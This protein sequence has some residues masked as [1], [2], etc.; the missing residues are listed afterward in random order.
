[1]PE[2]EFFLNDFKY[3]L[4]LFTLLLNFE[5]NLKPN[6]IQQAKNKFNTLKFDTLNL[7]KF[8]LLFPDY[9]VFIVAVGI[10]YTSL[11]LINE[12]KNPTHSATE[13]M[14]RFK[15]NNVYLK[16]YIHSFKDTA[17]L[18]RNINREKD[19][20]E[21]EEIIKIFEQVKNKPTRHKTMQWL[22][23]EFIADLLWVPYQELF[24]DLPES[25]TK[26]RNDAIREQSN[27][28][29]TIYTTYFD[30][31]DISKEDIY[32]SMLI[33]L[34]YLYAQYAT[35]KGRGDANPNKH[36]ETIV[37]SLQDKIVEISPL[38]M[39]NVYIK[40]FYSG[41]AIFDYKKKADQIDAIDD[42]F[43]QL[44]N[45]PLTELFSP[46]HDFSTDQRT[47]LLN[48]LALL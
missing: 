15:S 25:I 32:R 2:K 22:I 24:P 36:I 16:R 23:T 42:Y 17:Q 41:I 7:D 20:E 28:R 18:Y 38:K 43:E 48:T 30:G 10:V 11:E 3:T 31:F 39:K 47:Q 8:P 19:A 14:I 1:M 33:K 6:Q 5:P 45:S 13:D 46:F 40:G 26:P 4:P 12:L 37:G 44:Q 9:P 34:Y 35:N 27:R 29:V 21:L